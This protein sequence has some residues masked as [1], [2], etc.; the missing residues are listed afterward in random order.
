MGRKAGV[1]AALAAV[2][3]VS[4][5]FFWLMGGRG[6]SIQVPA[7]S[8]ARVIDGDTFVTAENQYIRVAST[9][10]PETGRCGGTEAKAALEKF[11][12][13]KPVYLKVVYRDPYQRL[14]SFVYTKERFVN[15]A[16][17][18]EGYSYY[19]RSS[20]GEIGEELKNASDKARE[21]K[22]GIFSET[23]TQ[24]ANHKNSSCNIKGNTGTDKI[25]YL[26]GCGVYPN[27][28]VQLY[29][30]DQWFCSEKEAVAAGFRKPEQCS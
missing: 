12:I 1:G 24:T 9:E 21:K 22:K 4:S 7:Y 27:V 29:R 10:A 13:G 23:C 15:E 18:L 11:V 16:T 3:I 6:Q 2:G 25:Y 5:G 19:S 26:P 28:E 30:G 20:P 17:L 14:V 8:V